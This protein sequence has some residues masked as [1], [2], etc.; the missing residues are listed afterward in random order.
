MNYFDTIPKDIIAYIALTMDL[1]E[2]SIYCRLSKKFYIN[3]CKNDNFWN[4]RLKQD[5]NIINSIYPKREYMRIKDTIDKI[6]KDQ[7]HTFNNL[8]TYASLNDDLNLVKVAIK[9]GADINYYNR[10]Y[11]TDSPSAIY[12][13]IANDNL[14]IL[15]YLIPLIKPPLNQIQ[16][17]YLL[18]LAADISQ[19]STVKYLVEKLGARPDA[20]GEAL[21]FALSSVKRLEISPGVPC[22]T[23]EPEY[24]YETT[25]ESIRRQMTEYDMRQDIVEYINNL[26]NIQ[27]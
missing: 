17:N 11:S 18:A 26:S 4:E 5:Y 12:E 14:E 21:N 25:N 2:I 15:D 9:Y 6:I 23:E 3:V 16:L 7:G 27:D 10:N 13:A 19:L 20:E 22:I 24:I 8:L 1:P